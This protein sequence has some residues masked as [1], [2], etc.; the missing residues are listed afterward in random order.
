MFGNGTPPRLRL[1]GHIILSHA[2]DGFA[3]AT[4]TLRAEE[5]A[6]PFLDDTQSLLEALK[7]PA[8]ADYG[9]TCNAHP[10]LPTTV[11][12]RCSPKCANKAHGLVTAMRMQNPSVSL[13]KTLVCRGSSRR[14]GRNSHETFTGRRLSLAFRSRTRTASGAVPYVLGR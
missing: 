5:V 14:G 3:A 4:L 10:S 13:C 6:S 2:W 12:A 11:L 1:S 7:A 8:E 9:S